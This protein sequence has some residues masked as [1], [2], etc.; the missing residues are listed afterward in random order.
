MGAARLRSADAAAYGVTVRM[1]SALIR[2][3]MPKIV[4]S[5]RRADTGP[6]A[7]RIFDRLGTYYGFESVFMDVDNIPFGADFR[8]HIQEELKH[9]DLLVVII[10]PRWMGV[11]EGGKTRLSDEIDPVRIEVETAMQLRVPIIP[12]LVDNAPMPK[13]S[14]LPDS[15]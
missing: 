2:G 5:Y 12:I 3:T 13:P 8:E 7:G 4:V 11:G 9:C 10:G 6:V 14:E 1:A 15:L